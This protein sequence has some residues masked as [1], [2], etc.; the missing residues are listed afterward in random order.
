MMLRA[1]GTR[2]RPAPCRIRSM[3]GVVGG[4]N[5]GDLTDFTYFTVGPETCFTNA[6]GTVPAGVGDSVRT[7]SSN[8]GP[9]L[10][11]E[12]STS[13]SR[14]ILRQDGNGFYY[15]E[16]S[17]GQFLALTSDT[18]CASTD[19]KV[20]A[21]AC[22]QLTSVFDARW[23]NGALRPLYLRSDVRRM[24]GPGGADIRAFGV[25]GTAVRS[26]VTQQTGTGSI[27]TWHVNGASVSQTSTSGSPA[28]YAIDTTPSPS[29]FRLRLADAA[30]GDG[31]MYGFGFRT[32]GGVLTAEELTALDTF[33][34]GLYTP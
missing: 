22:R 5:P 13:G 24:Y 29:T 25:A 3:C 34:Q 8:Y 12:Q 21:A 31:E 30:S 26:H 18:V 27:P 11:F 10:S 17:V 15:L 23:H 4:W 14:P 1:G 6:P 2:L 16:F 33:Q 32:G 19:A 9:S 7:F 28:E 20:V